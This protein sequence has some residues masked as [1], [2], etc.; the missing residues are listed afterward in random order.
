MRTTVETDA[1][2]VR[3]RDHSSRDL[4]G[5]MCG[6]LVL[7]FLAIGCL[8]FVIGDSPGK[9]EQPPEEFPKLD[10]TRLAKI[11]YYGSEGDESKCQSNFYVPYSNVDLS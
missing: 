7:I 11:L 5:K 1:T 2:T 9:P 3:V 10:D 8:S 6:V 4:L